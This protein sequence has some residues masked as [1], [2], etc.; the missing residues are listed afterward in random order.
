MYIQSAGITA[1][2]FHLF[3]RAFHDNSSIMVAMLCLEVA[4]GNC[5]R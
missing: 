3:S 1:A 5:A 4:E 2:H